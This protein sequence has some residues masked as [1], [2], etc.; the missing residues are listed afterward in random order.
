MSQSMRSGLVSSTDERCWSPGVSETAGCGN[1]QGQRRPGRSIAG[2]TT[3]AV[4]EC[5]LGQY[6]RSQF[7][8]CLSHELRTPL[9]A[10]IGFSEALLAGYLGALNDK[11]QEYVAD[12][13]RSGHR[14]LE[15]IADT[16]DLSRGE[17]E[18]LAIDE[19][20]VDIARVVTACRNR[21][22]RAIDKSG[23]RL[24]V[25]IPSD[26]PLLRADELWVH[27]IILN[28]LSNAVKF[29][30]LGG[31]VLV[32]ATCDPAGE[33]AVLVSDTGVGMTDDEIGRALR[34]FRCF[35][36]HV[37]RRHNGVGLGLTLAKILIE[38]HSGRM[39]IDSRPGAGTTVKI[40][41]PAE[42]VSRL[43]V[44]AIEDRW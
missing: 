32:A 21:L 7:F 23:L 6:A 15:V 26:L 20:H 29:T 11:Q 13:L 28:L 5:E 17:D 12:I 34:P 31:S 44:D 39:N 41:F 38:L 1:V 22:Q 19:R 33:M 37:S 4:V 40:S 18:A 43:E 14:V 30:P 42:R 10:V 3:A 8:A 25:K 2:E 27:Q 16:L 35:D 24:V 9:N 36:H